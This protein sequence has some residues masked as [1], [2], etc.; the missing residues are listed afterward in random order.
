[1]IA[2]NVLKLVS[3]DMSEFMERHEYH[4]R[5][6]GYFAKA[7]ET[8]EKCITLTLSKW[9]N[10]PGFH[11]DHYAAYRLPAFAEIHNR[12][13]LEVTEKEKKLIP[14][15]SV[16]FINLLP[17]DF[18]W[19]EVT[20]ATDSDIP[21]VARNIER[22]CTRYSFP[23][24]DKFAMADA[25]V[26][27]FRGEPD[28]WPVQDPILRLELLLLDGVLKHDLPSF[29]RW[30]DEALQ[31]CGSRTDGRAIWLS[32]LVRSLKKDYFP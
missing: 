1:M 3:E 29:N 32:N 7:G 12:Y 18:D 16:Y 27:G 25:I 26:S 23:F 14:T 2:K 21:L 6:M 28:V 30:S 10:G 5:G 4:K 9:L 20:V 11:V 22:I 24:L 19:K 17:Q 13:L 8:L 31:F 15:V